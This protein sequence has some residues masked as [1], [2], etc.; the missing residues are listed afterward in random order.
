MSVRNGSE[1]WFMRATKQQLLD[2]LERLQRRIDEFERSADQHQR[3][4]Q[5]PREGAGQLS[6][7]VDH[8]PA[9]IS[10]VDND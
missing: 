1:S 6:L 10:Y 5:A 3:V 8:L 9:L 2:E 7:I 4:N